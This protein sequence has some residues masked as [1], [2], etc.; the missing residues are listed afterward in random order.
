MY[1]AADMWAQARSAG[2]PTAAPEALD[3]DV[4]LAAQARQLGLSSNEFVVATG[5]L[6]H[7]SRFVPAGLW[8][9]ITP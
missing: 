8:Q 6:R 4:I 9:A 7:I 1:Q 3:G 5:N 2:L